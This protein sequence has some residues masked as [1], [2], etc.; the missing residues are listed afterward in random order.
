MTNPYTSFL[1]ITAKAPT[2]LKCCI[3]KKLTLLLAIWLMVG[4]N[5]FAQS[6]KQGND[7]VLKVNGEEMIGKVTE[8]NDGDIK[9]IY[10]GETL[11]YTIKKQDIL[12]ITFASGRVEVI[13]QPK[14]PSTQES[15][16]APVTPAV[17]SH[18]KVAILPFNLIIDNQSG[19]PELGEKV[20]N[21]CYN[22]M[23]KKAVTMKFQDPS[24]TNALL[25]KKNINK[26]NIKGFTMDE[27]CNV[28]GVEYVV[29]GIVTLNKASST[30][31]SYQNG[32][33]SKPSSTDPK[34]NTSKESGKSSTYSSSTTT[35]NYSTN[36][37]MNVFDEKGNKVFG[38]SHDSFWQ[39]PDAYKITLEFLA[40][41][42]PIYGK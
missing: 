29:Q 21:D 32:T 25:I 23:S 31:S 18:N 16:P 15:N 39:T 5:T 19:S 36:I 6:N 24:T 10:K 35:Q 3:M 12:R 4:L 14:L 20:Q 8:I 17:D 27:L 2:T 33:T 9:F 22:I 42:T 41:K 34:A 7:V 40:K 11:V 13:N 1:V 30:S 37:V 38:K 26:E 28:L